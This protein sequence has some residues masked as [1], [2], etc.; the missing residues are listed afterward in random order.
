M[1]VFK[2]SADAGANQIYMG[3]DYMKKVETKMED[4]YDSVITASGEVMENIG[5]IEAEVMCTER[6]IP[7]NARIRVLKDVKKM[8]VYVHQKALI[9]T[10]ILEDD[11]LI[12]TEKKGRP[13][14]AK[15]QSSRFHKPSLWY[16]ALGLIMLTSR[17]E[18]NDLMEIENLKNVNIQAATFEEHR[19]LI[20]MNT[21]TWQSVKSLMLK[22]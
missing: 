8:N 7:I 20:A 12:E 9:G 18:T 13:R 11:W 16:V 2:A 6:N 5:I 21:E 22:C 3:L 4:S 10:G 1:T 19:G 15:C 17:V 14:I